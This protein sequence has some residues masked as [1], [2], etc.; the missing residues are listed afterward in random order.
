MAVQIGLT[1]VRETDPEGFRVE[2][3]ILDGVGQT[4]GID[5]ELF[6]FQYVDGGSHD[7]YQHV[8]TVSNVKE[9]LKYGDTGWNSTGKLYRKRTANLVYTDLQ[10]AID[11][12]AYIKTRLGQLA[13]DF[14]DAVGAFLA[15]TDNYDY[16]SADDGRQLTL[17]LACTQ[18]ARNEYKMVATISASGLVGIERELFTYKLVGASPDPAADTYTRVAT[19]N[20]IRD[21]PTAGGWASG[22][23]Y[24]HYQVDRTYPLLGTAL[25][26]ISA[27]QTSLVS[28]LEVYDESTDE[29]E[30]SETEY[31][32]G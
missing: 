25:I 1:Q 26:T 5:P 2:N 14:E 16:K 31:F 29:F 22:D 20:D 24:R 28:L 15:L 23:Y 11:Q 12:A 19:V 6:V 8:S 30:G 7:I 27:I 13:I 3:A 32:N 18:P 10:A 9:L 21:Y 17:A 4:E